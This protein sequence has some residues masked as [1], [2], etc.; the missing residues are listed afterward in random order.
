MEPVSKPSP[1]VQAE[2]QVETQ[3]ETQVEVQAEMPSVEAAPT[4][5]PSVKTKSTK[6]KPSA[7]A[8][9][10]DATPAVAKS[11][12]IL[13]VVSTPIGNQL[14]ITLRGIK[15]LKAADMIVA[16]EGKI[17]ARLLR[18]HLITKN[19]EELNEHNE[20]E[21]TEILF[22]A[23]REGKD[24]ALISDA[25]T[26]L[27]ADPGGALVRRVIQAGMNVQAVP[28]VSSLMTALVTSGLP[29][30]EFVFAGF[31][32]REPSERRRQME[33]LAQ[34][35]RTVIVLETPYRL[36]PLLEAALL[37]M[38][39]RRA[40]VGC[41]L[42]MSS[43]T[44]HYGTFT[45][46]H[47]KFSEHKFKGEFVLC[48][49]GNAA[50]RA[51][52]ADAVYDTQA[53][54][55]EDGEIRPKKRFKKD[56]EFIAPPRD[57]AMEERGFKKTFPPKRF[58]DRK[59][60]GYAG[61]S[62]GNKSYDDK[63]R[64]RKEGESDGSEGGKR[65]DRPRFGAGGGNDRPRF[66]GGNKPYSSKPYGSKPYGDK[67][68]F[69]KEGESGGSEGGERSERPRFSGGSDSPRFGSGG[70]GGDSPRFG[71]KPRFGAG[72][73]GGAKPY[74]DKPRFRKEGESSSSEGGER[75][76]RPRF[77]SG[78]SGGERPRFGAGGSGG[79]KKFGGG[80][81]KSGGRPAG[82]PYGKPGGRPGGKPFG[83]KREE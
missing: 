46:L 82:K 77:G 56:Q 60:G 9:S 11:S 1:D 51:L 25:G 83:K 67:P 55:P 44:H 6:K 54:A 12:G 50:A 53:I 43:E 39:E 20:T 52:S 42:T 76:E 26:P 21:Q 45:E 69:R 34:E 38:P 19:I 41:N 74:G 40:Y 80:G 59:S 58:D 10:G 35:S 64:F 2:T 24:I 18:E 81:Y 31:L 23:L 73:S 8:E 78:A 66:D 4:K 61:K 36:Q 5:A 32:N 71:S 22:Q 49:E 29:M 57:F 48:F 47:D 70:S 13:F 72:G 16:E 75:S 14:D 17:A 62:Y 15:V 33:R 79:G 65:S 27:L 68:R 37:A 7:E 63:P 30:T 28:G 3:A